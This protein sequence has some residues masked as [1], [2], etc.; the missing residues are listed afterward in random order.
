MKRKLRYRDVPPVKTFSHICFDDKLEKRFFATNG[1]CTRVPCT[2]MTTARYRLLR[3]ALKSLL[4][5]VGDIAF[6]R[7]YS[8]AVQMRL[9]LAIAQ[10]RETLKGTS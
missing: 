7:V 1:P 5:S 2:L 10:A 8:D 6:G 3:R 4:S 9:E